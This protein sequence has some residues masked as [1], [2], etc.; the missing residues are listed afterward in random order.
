M[1]H[2]CPFA[3]ISGS[4]SPR[5][6]ASSGCERRNS[7][8]HIGWLRIF[9]ISSCG[10]HTMSGPPAWGL[11]EVPTTPHHKS[12]PCYRMVTISSCLDRSFGTN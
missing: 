11:S 1:L 3:M 6:G 12:W 4:M 9:W 5:H 7:L 2:V 8:Q 10:Q